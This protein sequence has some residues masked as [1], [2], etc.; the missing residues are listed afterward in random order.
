MGEKKGPY[1]SRLGK[2][3]RA[4]VSITYGD[5][6]KVPVNYKDDVWIEILVKHQ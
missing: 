2:I 5:W 4:N 3:V 6:R 1:M